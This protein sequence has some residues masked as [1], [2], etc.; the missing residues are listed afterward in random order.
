MNQSLL[1]VVGFLTGVM[2]V[3]FVATGQPLNLTITAVVFTFVL[4]VLAVYF[5][6]REDARLADEDYED[7]SEA[8]PVM[9]EESLM[10][11]GDKGDEPAPE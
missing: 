2:L 11:L 9:A 8:E 6:G 3:I 1:A 10:L 4:G 7:D 5:Y